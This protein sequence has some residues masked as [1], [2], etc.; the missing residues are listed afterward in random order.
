VNKKRLA[1]IGN[2][3][4]TGRLLDELERRGGL[5]TYEISVYGEEPHGCYN[6]ILLGRVLS[7]GKPDDIMLKPRDWYAERG[8]CFHAGLKVTQLDKGARRLT[9][10]D[11]E[12]HPY[13]VAVFAA[14]SAPFVPKMEG[15]TKSAGGYKDGVFL[16]RTIEDC[17]RMRAY[18]RPASSAVVVG[19]GLLGL[20]AAKALCDMGLHVTVLH[21]MDTLMNTQVD[22]L[23]GQM[24]KRSI[25]KLGIFVR[26]GQV[27]TAVLGDEQVEA[28]K[29]DS[30]E[31]LS[32]DLVV[33]SCGITPRTEA[34]R[35]SGV[36]CKRGILVN[37]A[38]ATQVP[39]VYA[40]GECAEHEGKV[41]GVVQPIWEQCAVLA[42]VLTAANPKA[43]YL[44]SRLYTR[45]KVAGV[46]V[47]SM[48]V[49]EPEHDSD[50]VVQ[51]IEERKGIYRKLIVR[52]DR[53]IG[54]VLIGS[55]EG[56][57]QLV[58][59]FDRGDPLP[60][61]RLDVLC[62]PNA[63]PAPVDL[64]VCNCNHV[65]ESTIVEAIRNGCDTLP[66]LADGTRAGTGCGSCRGQLASLILKN[67]APVNGNGN[68]AA[69]TAAVV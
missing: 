50:E 54:A 2:G 5:S 37:D 47:A 65:N 39:G 62:S 21:M 69:R 34:A 32:A 19:G 30:G 29:L 67:G 4:A 14:G 15:L 31:T 16:F 55:S 33:I 51:I 9:T 53:L 3:M 43:R 38:L 36:P 35:A 25:E 8:V 17:Q 7:G 45:L 49:V 56:A 26:A 68:G 42:D 61:N 18:S 12:T 13:D 63:A 20:E 23:G 22:R 40:V 27:A 6:R 64:E 60:A 59:L 52:G 58:Q 66:K 10:S 57:A 11:G 41:Y 46:D 44:G 48:G 28:V 1:I 24:L